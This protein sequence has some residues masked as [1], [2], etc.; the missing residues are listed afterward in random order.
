MPL[1]CTLTNNYNKLL[2]SLCFAKTITVIIR[3]R[4]EHDWARSVLDYTAVLNTLS[5][6]TLQGPACGSNFSEMF[7]VPALLSSNTT[8][9]KVSG[10]GGIQ[11][12]S[13]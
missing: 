12:V 9:C 8:S 3:S 6:I 11:C 4:P 10:L 13:L 2:H 7:Y 1:N 5:S